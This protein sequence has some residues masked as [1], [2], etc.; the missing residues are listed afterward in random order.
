MLVTDGVRRVTGEFHLA[1]AALGIAE[2]V[3]SALV[4]GSMAR[5]MKQLRRTTHAEHH[6]HGI[7]WVD[8]FLGVMLGVEAFMHQHESGHL[9]RPTVLVAIL[10]FAIGIFHPRLAAFG[11]RRRAL[12]ITDAGLSLPGRPFRYR[13]LTLPWADVATIEIDDRR[14]RVRSVDGTERRFDLADA[15]HPDAIRAAL[16]EAEA[17]RQAALTAD[18]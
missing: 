18:N 15:V 12:H 17:R 3:T 11:D 16:T 6:A 1:S 13:R 10:T 2:I 5:A 4:I 9:P 14:A 8:I 7:D